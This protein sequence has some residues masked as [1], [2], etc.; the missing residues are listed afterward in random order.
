MRKTFIKATNLINKVLNVDE[1]KDNKKHKKEKKY[2]NM[3]R[4]RTSR[5]RR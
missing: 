4:P 5:K 1:K 3:H 2:I